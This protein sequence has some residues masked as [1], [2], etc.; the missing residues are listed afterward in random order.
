MAKE[1]QF[2]HQII[3][4][5]GKGNWDRSS[6]TVSGN[7]GADGEHSGTSVLQF[8]QSPPVG[9]LDF[10]RVPSQVSGKSSGLK[11]GGDTLTNLDLSFPVGKLVDLNGG[12]C[13]K[14][15]SKTLDWEGLHGIKGFHGLK[16]SEFDVLGDTE[17]LMRRDV[18]EGDSELVE[19]V[20]NGGNHGGTSVLKFGSAEES[21]GL[22]R[23]IFRCKLVPVCFSNENG[24]T[25]ERSSSEAWNLLFCGFRVK[26]K[27]L[28]GCFVG[29]EGSGAGEKAEEREGGELHFH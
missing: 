27:A 1:E 15:L 6:N 11:T 24:L 23:T 26:S 28:G 5:P 22:S 7:P 12:N 17:V 18:I 9:N 2:F 3:D 10:Q 16:V 21:S 20:S 25:D 19:S 4:L 29:G 14:H 13:N 8:S